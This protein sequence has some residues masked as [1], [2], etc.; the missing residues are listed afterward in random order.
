[1]KKIILFT[2]ST[3]ALAGCG[4]GPDNGWS[5]DCVKHHSET[6]REFAQCKEKL[7]RMRAA[8]RHAEQNGTSYAAGGEAREIPA[9]VVSIDAE[10]ATMESFSQ[11]GK[12]TR[13]GPEV[14]DEEK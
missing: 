13:G 9:G 2:V 14:S 7:K 3:F 4:G 8:K 5:N 10:G 1:M 6:G 11:T 12:R